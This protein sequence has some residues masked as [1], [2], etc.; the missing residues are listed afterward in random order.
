[1]SKVTNKTNSGKDHTNNNGVCEVNLVVGGGGGG[2][3]IDL[4]QDAHDQNPHHL[5]EPDD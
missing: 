4:E 1:M 5:Q 3:V 2:A